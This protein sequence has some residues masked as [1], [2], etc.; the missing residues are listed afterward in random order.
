MSERERWAIDEMVA[1]V[2]KDLYYPL[3]AHDMVSSYFGLTLY[4]KE[5]VWKGAMVILRD[6]GFPVMTTTPMQ[7][8]LSSGLWK[9]LRSCLKWISR[10]WQ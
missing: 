8:V 5:N 7:P 10:F 2:E 9:T 3:E 6:K 4:E 1:M